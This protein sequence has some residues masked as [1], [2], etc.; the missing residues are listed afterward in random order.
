LFRADYFRQ[1]LELLKRLLSG[2]GGWCNSD[3][4]GSFCD[5][6]I[7]M[8]FLRN[9]V[10][11]GAF[12]IIQQIW[13]FLWFAVCTAICIKAPSSHDLV[14]KKIR[15]NKWFIYLGILFFLSFIGLSQISKFIYF[16]F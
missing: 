13:L 1:S 16:N 14:D 11:T 4:L 10:P 12:D 9:L 7:A 15:S 5:T 2:G 6:S 8:A 3:M